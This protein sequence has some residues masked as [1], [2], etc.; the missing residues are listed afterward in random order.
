M[1]TICTQKLQPQE[2]IR[3]YQ[4]GFRPVTYQLF[5]LMELQNIYGEPDNDLHVIFVDSLKAYDSLER[6]HMVKYMEKLNTPKKLIDLVHIENHKV[7]W[8]AGMS[9]IFS[10]RN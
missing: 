7:N 3:D 2:Q 1:A 6:K 5:L 9:E 4:A 8:K 10:V